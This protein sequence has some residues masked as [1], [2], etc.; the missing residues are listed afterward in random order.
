[1]LSF[2][3]L[4]KIKILYIESEDFY[5][6]IVPEH[7]IDKIDTEQDKEELENAIVNKLE[8]YI[9]KRMYRGV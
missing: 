7:I 6:V 5:N 1:M 2:N 9:L 3:E 8:R 4:N